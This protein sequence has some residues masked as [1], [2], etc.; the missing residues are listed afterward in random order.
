MLEYFEIK[1]FT[2]TYLLLYYR[3]DFHKEQAIYTLTKNKQFI[4]LQIN[5]Y[6]QN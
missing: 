1:I 6:K 2:V 3:L 5:H 4:H